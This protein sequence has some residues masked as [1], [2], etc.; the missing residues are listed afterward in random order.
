MDLSLD[1]LGPLYAT[2][3]L[4]PWYRLLGARVGKRAEISTAS[5]ISPD[6][7]DIA[8]EGFIADSVSLGAARVKDGTLTIGPCRI[9]K[10]TFIGNSGLLPP[11]ASIGDNSLIGCLSLPPACAKLAAHDGAS[12]LGSPSFFLPQRQKSAPFPEETTFKPTKKLWLQ[13]ALI[14][15]F[16]VTLPS[17]CFIVLT[18]LLL[19]VVV[20]IQDRIDLWQLIALF[21]LMYAG[22]GVSASLFT[23]LMKWILMGKYRPGEWPLWSTF[24]WRN[25]LVTSLRE[26]LSDLYLV[27][28]LA[29]T[30]FVCWFFRLLG[31]KIGRRVYMET[32]ELT[33]FDLVKIGDGAALNKDCTAQTHLFEDR[34]FKM[35]YIDVGP[36]CVVGELS[37]V[38]Y[39]TKLEAGAALDSL[40]LLMK[41]EVLPAHTRW[42]GIPAIRQEESRAR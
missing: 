12:W 16:R 13:R 35:S 11:G 14:E 40:S 8:D 26:N 6:L 22:C 15:F 42:Q 27:E 5:F 21:P 10:R 36:G 34:V 32:T 30:P 39:D 17:T 1:T 2:I 24:V 3:Y 18:S 41:G 19:S 9:G 38:L 33:E 7:L 31:A 23:V 28:T 25:E 37:L 20:L 29:G 4:A